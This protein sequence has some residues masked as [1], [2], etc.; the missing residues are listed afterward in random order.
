MRLR[1]EAARGISTRSA[2]HKPSGS[3]AAARSPAA[4]HGSRPLLRAA[5]RALAAALLL[6][7]YSGSLTPHAQLANSRYASLGLQPLPLP[8]SQPSAG[9]GS[10]GGG[11]AG[12]LFLPGWPMLDTEGQPIQAH[13]GGILHWN[14]TYYWCAR[15]PFCRPCRAGVRR[16]AAVRTAIRCCLLLPVPWR[17]SPRRLPASASPP[18]SLAPCLRYGE[19]KGGPTYLTVDDEAEAEAEAAMLTE[20]GQAPGLRRGGG[21]GASAAAAAAARRL[22][23]DVAALSGQQQ[24]R[25]R[26]HGS[27]QPQRRLRRKYCPPRV[28]VIGVSCYSSPDLQHWR[29]EGEFRGR[30]A[31]AA[32]AV[33]EQAGEQARVRVRAHVAG[34]PP[35]LP[36]ASPGAAGLVLRAGAHPNLAPGRVLE[37]PKVL[38]NPRTKKFVM[39]CR[40]PP[41][42]APPPLPLPLP[43]PPPPLPPPLR[44]PP[45]PR[46]LTRPPSPRPCR[47]PPPP[48]P[49]VPQRRQVSA[50][51]GVQAELAAQGGQRMICF[52]AARKNSPSVRVAPGPMG[53]ADA[54]EAAASPWLSCPYGMPPLALPGTTM[55][56]RPGS[57]W[58]TPP[59]VGCR[60]PAAAPAA[61]QPPPGRP[62]CRRRAHAS[63]LAPFAPPPPPH[64]TPPRAGPFTFLRAF[65]PHGQ[66]SRDLTLFQVRAIWGVQAGVT[67]GAGGGGGPATAATETQGCPAPTPPPLCTPLLS[68]R[69][70]GGH[71]L[72]GLRLRGE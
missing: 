64:P 56:P 20:A 11:A 70:R 24:R 45:P 35:R 37:R 57:R 30:G 53:K 44:T 51:P 28:D 9:R 69:R 17:P 31:A 46:P 14:G 32:A 55:R 40:G 19:H 67:G 13:G 72:A 21:N 47:S 29:N 16:R 12:P 3:A 63:P 38:W 22:A 42:A 1:H 23:A 27:L 68:G 49:V 41:G 48:P 61:R 25:R 65:R 26:Q 66:M 60:E 39:V 34:R 7:L 59:P 2:V 18:W 8:P 36:C 4:R 58:P 15:V 50:R 62:A 33:S 54:P 6:A 52:W 5:L 71:R 43:T 10:S